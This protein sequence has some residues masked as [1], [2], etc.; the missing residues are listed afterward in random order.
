MAN[1]STR[2]SDKPD[3]TDDFLLTAKR[4]MSAAKRFFDKVMG[5]N[6]D[7]DKVAMDRS[8]A[9]KAAIYA[10][11]APC[12]AS[13]FSGVLVCSASRRSPAA[14]AKS[15]A[16]ANSQEDSVHTVH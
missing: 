2:A 6:G 8:G 15:F 11:K 9:N 4:D 14:T 16:G 13:G 3:K 10:I 12:Y 1:T 5:A 7:T